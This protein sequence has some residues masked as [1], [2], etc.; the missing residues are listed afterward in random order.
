MPKQHS[1]LPWLDVHVSPMSCADTVDY[2]LEPHSKQRLLL[3][4]NLHSCF[5]HL[6]DAVFRGLYRAADVVLIDGFP[7]YVE[8]RM[9]GAAR[10]GQRQGSTDWFTALLP[11]AADSGLRIAYV[12]ARPE[13]LATAEANIL[14]LYP[15]LRWKSW[16]GYRDDWTQAIKEINTFAPSLVLVG[17]GMPLQ[18]HWI[19]RYRGRLSDS[20]IIANVGACI[21]YFGGAQRLAPRWMGP[22]GLEWMFR[23][24]HDPRRL[25][26]RYL[27]EPVKFALLRI[28]SRN[29]R[30]QAGGV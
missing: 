13:V 27:A 16:H 23:L 8:A 28:R 20:V 7:V 18:E 26:Y 19:A 22:L 2:I 11:L 29:D 4:H 14:Q 17:M 3:N 5:L 15:T 25:A 1:Y 12:G 9:R 30:P 21:D 10:P 24:L 6:N